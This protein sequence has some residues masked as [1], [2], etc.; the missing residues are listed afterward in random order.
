MVPVTAQRTAAVDRS[1]WMSDET[2]RQGGDDQGRRQAPRPWSV[3]AEHLGQHQEQ[4]E[5]GELGGLHGEGAEGD[6]PA[7]PP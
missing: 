6:P 4:A 5:L 7:G 2:D 1:G 3:A